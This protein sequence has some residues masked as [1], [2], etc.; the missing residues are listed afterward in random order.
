MSS[1]EKK[2]MFMNSVNCYHRIVSHSLVVSLKGRNILSIYLPVIFSKCHIK[3]YID[4]KV[5]SII[6]NKSYVSCAL[7]YWMH[8]EEKCKDHLVQCGPY[9]TCSFLFFIN[10]CSVLFF[11]FIFLIYFN[12]RLIT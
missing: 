7:I 1:G 10:L 4:F 9:Y 11:N 6:L 8:M 12:W 3:V 5:A 2:H